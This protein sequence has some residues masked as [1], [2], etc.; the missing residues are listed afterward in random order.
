MDCGGAD[1][2]RDSTQTWLTACHLPD[3][4]VDHKETLAGPNH[5]GI[6]DPDI[7]T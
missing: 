6:R 5:G 1:L 3:V 2:A 4:D 7:E